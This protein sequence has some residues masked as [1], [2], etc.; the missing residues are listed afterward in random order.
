MLG[1]SLDDEG[2]DLSMR[3]WERQLVI[4]MRRAIRLVVVV[5]KRAIRFVCGMSEGE[6]A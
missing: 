4:S 6:V 1:E 2:S 5:V 3:V